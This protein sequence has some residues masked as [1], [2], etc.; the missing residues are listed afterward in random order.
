MS[1]QT[2]N[3][4]SKMGAFLKTVINT[5]EIFNKKCYIIQSCS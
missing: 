2:S 4:T 3:Q 5:Y 1:K